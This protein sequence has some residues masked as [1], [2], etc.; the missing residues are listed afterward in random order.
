M[1]AGNQKGKEESLPGNVCSEISRILLLL[2][3]LSLGSS[4]L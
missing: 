1:T 2:T 3:L 4:K